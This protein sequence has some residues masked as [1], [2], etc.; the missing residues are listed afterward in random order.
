MHYLR[1]VYSKV[2]V[3]VVGFLVTLSAI[4]G[5]CETVSLP[6]IF[7]ML[8]TRSVTLLALNVSKLRRRKECLEAPLLKTNYV[9]THALIVKLLFLF[10]E[11][12]HRMG[13]PCID[14][15]LIFLLVTTRTR[16]ASY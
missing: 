9:T 11:S 15:H 10:L 6:R 16:F 8:A 3:R 1:P 14:P 7:R 12:G 4:R 5:R 13:V 2:E